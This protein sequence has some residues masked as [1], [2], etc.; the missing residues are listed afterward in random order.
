MFFNLNRNLYVNNSLATDAGIQAL[1][2]TGKAKSLRVLSMF[3]QSDPF[4]PLHMQDKSRVT[5]NGILM[6]LNNLPAL[7]EL[8]HDSTVE[9]LAHIYQTAL[10]GGVLANTKFA[11]KALTI[12]SISPYEN[13]NLLS[14]VS[15]CKTLRKIQI[16]ASPSMNDNDLLGLLSA[17]KLSELC[18]LFIS[19]TKKRKI[20]FDGGVAPLLQ[21]SSIGNSLKSLVLCHL[22]KVN[23]RII[24]EYCPNLR[25]LI[26]DKNARYEGFRAVDPAPKTLKKLEHLK[27][28]RCGSREILLLLLSSP[29]VMSVVLRDC[30]A[31]NDDVVQKVVERGLFRNLEHFEVISND[32]LSKQGIDYL[33]IENNP[34]KVIRLEGVAKVTANAITSWRQ[35]IK[36]KNWDLSIIEEELDELSWY[37][38]DDSDD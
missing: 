33:M 30:P 2:V 22:S 14:A 7:N 25:S 24:T 15:L 3:N 6:A 29:C 36:D 23:I 13:G 28:V 37:I 11:L 19:G 26:L 12:R 17:E 18:S 32:L 21:K 4:K 1:C 8:L 35:K 20:T 27:V 16:T 9:T 34:L 10:R 38:I 5:L 31:L